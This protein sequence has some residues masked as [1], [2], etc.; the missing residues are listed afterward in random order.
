MVSVLSWSISEQLLVS[1]PIFPGEC[2]IS[3]PASASSS[4]KYAMLGATFW[5][6]LAT[7]NFEIMVLCPKRGE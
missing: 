5:E 1:L 3:V 6:R 2:G 7:A 4:L